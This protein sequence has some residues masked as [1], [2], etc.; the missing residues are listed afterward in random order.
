MPNWRREPTFPNVPDWLRDALQ[1]VLHDMQQPHPIEI[2][3]GY[4]PATNTLRFSEQGQAGMSFY[5]AEET[6]V[7]L[8]VDLADFL[9]D[10][11]FDQAAGAWGQA[12][13]ACPGH[14]HPVS[15][16]EVDGDAWWVCPASGARIARIGEFSL[17]M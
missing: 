4:E 12:R 9:Q 17:Q 16:E 14:P 7:L 3:V 13:P 2:V 8:T 1:A 15:P 11:F 5:E 6:G 10:Q